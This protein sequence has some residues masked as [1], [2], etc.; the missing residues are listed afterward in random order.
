MEVASG[1]WLGGSGH[2]SVP[3]TSVGLRVPHLGTLTGL[4]VARRSERFMPDQDSTWQGT[5]RGRRLALSSDWVAA[6]RRHSEPRIAEALVRGPVT[7]LLSRPWGPGFELRV[8]YGQVIVS[9]QGHL[10]RDED[11]DALVAAAEQLAEGVR[12][13][14]APPLALATLDRPLPPPRWLP[15]VR[16]HPGDV[17]TLLPVR[18]RLDRVVAIADERGLAIEDPRAFHTAFGAIDVPGEAFAVLRSQLPGTELTGR[19]LCCAERPM[20]IP[21]EIGR[22][23]STP[24]GDAGCD[25]VVVEVARRNP[26]DGV[27]G[28]DGRRR[29]RG[30]RGGRADCLAPAPRLAG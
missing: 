12:R 1:G 4:H 30:C 14:C 7:D 13:I 15:T 23:L 27:R 9:Q 16:R 8:E 21:E 2:F 20:Y 18:A 3:Y 10:T 5:W 24:G 11:L 22:L 25:V 19:L 28:R 29:A 17:H 26:R 6:V